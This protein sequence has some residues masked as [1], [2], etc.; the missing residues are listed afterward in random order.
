[1]IFNETGPY[2]NAMDRDYVANRGTEPVND[3]APETQIEGAPVPAPLF[4]VNELGQTVTEGRQFGTFI[5]SVQAA[6]RAGAGTVEL[7]TQM[8][9]TDR[10]VGAEAYG[11]E[12]REDL[13]E[14]AKANEIKFTGV[15]SP[16]QVG[17]LSGYLDP[18]RG[19][20]WEQRKFFLDEVKRAINFLADISPTGGAVVV[21]TG[22]YQRPISEQPWARDPE[23]PDRFMFKGYDEE[24]FTT[25][26]PLVDK[27][28]GH[29]I[30]QVRKNQV[31][32]RAVWNRYSEANK[33]L[34]G[35]HGGKSYYDANGHIVQPEDYVDYEGNWMPR[36]QR[37]PMYDRER[38][39][40]VVEEQEWDDF[41]KEAEEINAEFMK[42]HGRQPVGDDLVTP[43]E[44]FLR[45]T[46]ET[47]KRISEGW[48]GI[49]AH[50]MDKD[51]ERVEK[52]K[53]VLA[54][55]EKLEKNIPEDE[56]WRLARQVR[57]FGG[58]L[59]EFV[60]PDTKYPTEIIKENIHSLKDRIFNHREAVVGQT[61]SAMDQ[62]ILQKNAVSAWKYAQKESIKSYAE[63]AIYAMDQTKERRLEK[64]VFV[65][66]E[67]LFPE[68]GWGTHPEELRDL[69]KWARKEMEDRLVK[70]R[71]FSQDGAKKA[72]E[73][74]IKATFDF[75]HMGMWWKHFEPKYPGEPEDERKKRFDGW[76]LKEVK[77]LVDEGL[78]GNL[79]VVDG[80]GGAH[81]HLPP[82]QGVFPIRTV[83]EYMKSK[84]YTGSLASEAW[85]EGPARQLTKYWEYMGAYSRPTGL[86]GP[87]APG[88]PQR[89]SDVFQSY[90]GKTYPPNYIFGAYAPSNDWTLWSQVPM[91]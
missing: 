12:A 19:F 10:G 50:D 72:A 66:P 82:G 64:P 43:E 17:N 2:Y 87:V 24:P 77:K 68:M 27:R 79:H 71:N 51:F 53:K 3:Y 23:N 84:G 32:P 18:N 69:V 7:A 54:F 73:E 80:M 14:L 88:G 6:I 33:D 63:A 55:Y 75:Q 1:M 13:R 78:I 46:T 15:H 67:N 81:H 16:T 9:G 47:Q 70:E 29:V 40:F 86:V 22:E 34:F 31:V 35:K 11:K 60:P 42:E 8:A 65:S 85:E 25:V 28:T 52:L 62:D 38:N 4:D 5:Q 36:E 74:H 20:S 37:V 45:A 49:Y 76:Y 90:F 30:Q 56:K 41:V 59:E 26:M 44:A 89:W 91:E 61:Q 21:H 48:A 57:E 83:L 39:R 58:V